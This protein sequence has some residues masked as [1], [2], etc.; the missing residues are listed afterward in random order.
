MNGLCE[1][2]CGRKTLVSPCTDRWHGWV[3]GEPRRFL[4]GHNNRLRRVPDAR[5]EDRALRQPRSRPEV[6]PPSTRA[7]HPTAGIEWGGSSAGRQGTRRDQG[8]RPARAASHQT[9]SHQRPHRRRACLIWQ[10]SLNDRGYGMSSSGGRRLAHKVQW[11]TVHGPVPDGL[12]L[13]HLCRQRDCVNPAHLEPVT[14]AENMRR[15]SVA[16]AEVAAAEGSRIAALRVRL[17]W[18]QGQ[19]AEA[20]GVSRALVTLWEGG[21]HRVADKYEPR[22]RELAEGY[23]HT[24]E[25][26]YEQPIGVR[27]A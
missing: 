13:D 11:E 3:K 4:A 2:G 24:P 15:S 16:R 7:P 9:G 23:G 5:E 26:T 12:E 27:A 10:G 17:Q 18:S 1:C 20:L 8:L 25:P 19:L 22:L 14:H 21:R 6:P